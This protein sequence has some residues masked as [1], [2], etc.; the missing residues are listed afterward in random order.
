MTRTGDCIW[1][2]GTKECGA[3]QL[4]PGVAKRMWKTRATLH[5]P[6]SPVCATWR[7]KACIRLDCRTVVLKHL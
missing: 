7:M 1:L 4:G 5:L 2:V 3:Q 6:Q